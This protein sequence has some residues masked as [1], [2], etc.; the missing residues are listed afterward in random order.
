MHH[1]RSFSAALSVLLLL[2]LL[3]GSSGRAVAGENKNIRLVINGQ[4]LEAVL[5]DNPAGRDFLAMLPLRLPL[6][7]FNN[8]E[9]IGYL[10]RRLETDGTPDD[11]LPSEGDLTYYAP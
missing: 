11:C 7:D 8:T 4:T 10:P 9:K 3:P 6:Q 5:E 1:A 2:S